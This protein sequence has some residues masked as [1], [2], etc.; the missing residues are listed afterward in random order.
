MSVETNKELVLRV[1]QEAF[2]AGDLRVIDE[3][4][5][6]NGID[7]QHPDEPSFAEHLK[8]VVV[9]MRTAF[10]DLRFDVTEIIGEDDWV[11]CH[12]IMTGTNLVSGSPFSAFP[13]SD[14]NGFPFTTT[15]LVS[16]PLGFALGWAGTVL[17]G[18]RKAEEQRRQYEAVEAWILAGVARRGI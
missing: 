4:V 18:R 12:S 7:R 13:Q 6:M 8:K 9:A 16:I 15:A 2:G 17:S 10:P 14:F 3:V 11:A 1:F 5:A